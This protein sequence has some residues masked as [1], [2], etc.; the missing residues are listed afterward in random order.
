MTRRTPLRLAG[1]IAGFLG[2]LLGLIFLTFLLFHLGKV[3]PARLKLGPMASEASVARLRSDLGLNRPILVQFA[4]FFTHA[5][6]GDLGR[7]F[8]SELPALPLA[9]EKLHRTFLLVLG[10]LVPALLLSYALVLAT[11]VWK[12]QE[13][14]I[15]LPARS[16]AILPSFVIAV[17]GLLLLG[18]AGIRLPSGSV[19]WVPCLLLALFPTASLTLLLHSATAVEPPPRPWLLARSFGFS[20]FTAFHRA[21]FSPVAVPWITAWTTQVS[22]AVFTAMVLEMVLTIDGGGNLLAN[23]VQQRDLPVLQAVLLL[24]GAVFLLLQ[25]GASWL[26]TILDPRQRK[27]GSSAKPL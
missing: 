22:Q 7:S 20:P 23:A 6:Q 4:D 24:N 9:A 19:G 16:L 2:K 21:L 26:A 12:E 10:G 17:G 5:I 8:R 18:L 1:W 11:S 3:D 25:S 13:K 14:L 15:L 27:L